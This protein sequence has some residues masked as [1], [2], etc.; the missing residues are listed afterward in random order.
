MEQ[1]GQSIANQWSYGIEWADIKIGMDKARYHQGDSISCELYLKGN[2]KRRSVN[3][4][5]IMLEATKVRTASNGYATAAGRRYFETIE[6]NTD[7]DLELPD[8]LLL[9]FTLQ[10][11]EN[12][13]FT[14]PTLCWSIS[15]DFKNASGSTES[16]TRHFVV[17]PKKVF[18]DILKVVESRLGFS[19]NLHVRHW[20]E[21]SQK[22]R[23]FL[24]PSKRFKNLL[25][26][27]Q[28]EIRENPNGDV[29]GEFEFDLQERT[30]S[31]YVEAILGRDKVHLPF[32]LKSKELYDSSG[33]INSDAVAAYFEAQI[34]KAL[35]LRK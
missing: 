15:V 13:S 16:V 34:D 19:E 27:I 9:P 32:I 25:D 1:A 3:V 11:P 23:F 4:F 10:L 17:L 7:V 33:C 2:G 8:S 35:A 26:F 29:E 12:V 18:M 14:D 31:D 6:I 30:I 28:L 20:I 5:K 22:T 24:E 21:D